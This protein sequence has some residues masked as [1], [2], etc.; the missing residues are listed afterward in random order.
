MEEA[1]FLRKGTSPPSSK[2][3]VY[4][5]LSFLVCK[6]ATR[7]RCSHGCEGDLAP[8]SQLSYLPPPCPGSFRL[9]DLL[10]SVAPKWLKTFESV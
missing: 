6:M 1:I 8:T 7:G 4:L 2:I 10:E 3:V 9:R 5:T